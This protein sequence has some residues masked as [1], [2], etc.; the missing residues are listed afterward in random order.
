MLSLM[1]LLSTAIYIKDL[2]KTKTIPPIPITLDQTHVCNDIDKVNLF[3]TYSHSVMPP[4]LLV[5]QL[6]TAFHLYLTF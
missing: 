5:L 1:H 3:N 6:L 2:T 4:V